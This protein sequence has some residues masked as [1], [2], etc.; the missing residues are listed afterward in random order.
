MTFFGTLITSFLFAPLNAFL[1]AVLLVSKTVLRFTVF[2]DGH[3]KNALLLMLFTFA[4][5]VTDC[6][7]LFCLN[8]FAAMLVTLYVS[9]LTEIVAGI[10]IFYSYFTS[11]SQISAREI[12]TGGVY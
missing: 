10:V 9:L 7:F 5:T 4:P 11:F 6:N 1:L 2:N 12:L 3:L 8:A